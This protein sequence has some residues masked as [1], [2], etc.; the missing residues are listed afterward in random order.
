[1]LMIIALNFDPDHHYT[2]DEQLQIALAAYHKQK[3]EH[4]NGQRKV[5]PNVTA[6]ARLYAVNGSTLHGHI[7]N[8][9]RKT[10]SELHSEQLSREEESELLKRALFMDD[11]NILPDRETLEQLALSLIRPR[12]PGQPRIGQHWIHRFLQRHKQEC[13]FVFAQQIPANRANAACWEIN[14][15]FFQKVSS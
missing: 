1:L 13:K 3:Q 10:L 5:P 14:L 11:F 12:S 7:K 9:S 2:A 4:D 8:P 15:D 6:L